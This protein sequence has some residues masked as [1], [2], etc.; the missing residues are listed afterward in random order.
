MTVRS[1]PR[2]AE[3][4]TQAFFRATADVVTA[5][6]RVLVDRIELLRTEL[7]G[8]AKDLAVAIGVVVAAGVVVFIGWGFL[9]VALSFLLARFLPWDAATGIVAVLHIGSGAF[10][11][12][13]ALRRFDTERRMMAMTVTDPTAARVLRG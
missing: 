3:G 1:E 7:A 12:R 8:D 2:V 6:Q 11:A 5:S 10:L 9:A 13:A 4:P